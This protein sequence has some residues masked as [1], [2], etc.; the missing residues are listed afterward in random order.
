MTS[1][2]NPQELSS[3]ANTYVT[4]LAFNTAT[5][6]LTATR[7][8]GE[9]LTAALDGRYSTQNT[10]TTSATFNSS[11]GVLT[12]NQTD[13]SGTVTVDLDG[14]FPTQN[15]HLNSAS[16]DSG[17]KNL[18]LDIIDPASTINVD[19]TSLA[20]EN[21]HLQSASYDQPTGIL[22]LNMINPA[23]TIS[24]SIGDSGKYLPIDF[25][26]LRS[27]NLNE[28]LEPGVY[29]LYIASY[30]KPLGAYG[31]YQFLTV[32]AVQTGALPEQSAV[33]QIYQSGTVTTDRNPNTRVWIRNSSYV[34]DSR[35]FSPWTELN[36]GGLSGYLR[37]D[38]G[39]DYRDFNHE[40]YRES[41]YY[42]IGHVGADPPN[43]WA[44]GPATYPYECHFA[45]LQTVL[46]PASTVDA[47]YG[48]GYQELSCVDH[49]SA[50]KE[51]RKYRRVFQASSSV[52]NYTDWMEFVLDGV[53]V[54]RMIYQIT[55]HVYTGSTGIDVSG[56]SVINLTT[57][58][59]QTYNVT[60]LMNGVEGQRVDLI[61]T[62]N[63][64]MV[65]IHHYTADGLTNIVSPN[66]PGTT[67]NLRYNRG[68]SF[69]FD[70]QYWYPTFSNTAS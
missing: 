31:P 26:G 41:G 44:N 22:S 14:R 4:A 5:G 7:N 52:Q 36:T 45:V 66:G 10:F 68:A 17:T 57:T 12:L 67:V 47:S 6:V 21:T 50:T 59:S 19:L 46:L 24:V 69:I 42:Y 61:K 35:M 25:D 38:F 32:Y 37:G 23:S 58:I 33:L 9:E 48:E 49:D 18:A 39:A 60:R 56:K 29:S 20:E 3:S 43:G 62:T 30:P 28:L 13:P 11:D 27:E 54:N 55:D 40:R 15:T 70:G 63:T 64:G 65:V 34:N 51:V 16:Y 8:D 1:I 53:P 2:Y